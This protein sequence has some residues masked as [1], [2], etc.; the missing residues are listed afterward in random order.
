VEDHVDAADGG[1][2]ALVRTEIALDQVDVVLQLREIGATPGR[3]VVEDANVVAALEQRANQVGADEAAAAGDEGL[4]RG[5][6]AT[7]W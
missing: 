1:V 6:S 5:T 2:H 7:T 4:Q 3:E